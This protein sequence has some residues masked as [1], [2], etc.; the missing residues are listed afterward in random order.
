MAE[1]ERIRPADVAR[2]TSLRETAVQ[3]GLAPAEVDELMRPV[4]RVNH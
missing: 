2:M 3:L 4:G 1:A